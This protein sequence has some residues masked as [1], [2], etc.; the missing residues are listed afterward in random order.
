MRTPVSPDMALG[1][2][3]SRSPKAGGEGGTLALAVGCQV[4]SLCPRVRSLV[5]ILLPLCQGDRSNKAARATA[6]QMPEQQK[7]SVGETCASC[8]SPGLASKGS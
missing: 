1:E 7:R 6:K 4:T 3:S 5:R 2:C 8:H